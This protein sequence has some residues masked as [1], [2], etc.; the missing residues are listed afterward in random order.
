MIKCWCCGLMICVWPVFALAHLITSFPALGV[1]SL[2]LFPFLSNL[3][4]SLTLTVRSSVHVYLLFLVLLSSSGGGG[5]VIV[6]TI[7]CFC[8]LSSPTAAFRA[9][10]KCCTQI[11]ILSLFVSLS[12]W[13]SSDQQCQARL[14]LSSEDS[15]SSNHSDDRTHSVNERERG[16]CA[17]AN[18]HWWNCTA[19]TDERLFP[20]PLWFDK[21]TSTNLSV[22]SIPFPLWLCVPSSSK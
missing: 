6:A 20:P 8:P 9:D 12:D 13:S 16:Q 21:W 14:H 11:D 2:F 17:I 22:L 1:A 19:S 3:S 10:S 4:L 5:S 15:S 7:H 18:Q